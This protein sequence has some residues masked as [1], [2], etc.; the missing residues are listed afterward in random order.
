MD[1]KTKILLLITWV[2]LVLMIISNIASIYF[3]IENNNGLGSRVENTVQKK[4]DSLPKPEVIQG[5]DG[6]TPQ[7]NVDYFNGINGKDGQSIQGLQGNKG[8]SAYDI[9]VK[10]GFEGSE[11]DWVLSLKGD[12][13]NDGEP[14]KTPYIRCNTARN[15]WEVKYSENEA[16][17]I[18]NGEIVVC[19]IQ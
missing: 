18:M 12:N 13:G 5:K 6:Y 4:I 9:A 19:A 16:W 3:V 15:R 17:Q 14:G 2:C 1:K 8:D 7:L 11:K 10:N